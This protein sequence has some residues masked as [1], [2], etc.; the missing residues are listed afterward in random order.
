MSAAT[1]AIETGAPLSGAQSF[2]HGVLAAPRIALFDFY[3]REFR[4]V[5]HRHPVVIVAIDDQSLKRVAQWPWP[6]QVLAQLLKT[7]L[8]ARPAAVGFDIMFSE[9]DRSSPGEWL[10]L[11]GPIPEAVRRQIAVLPSHEQAFADAIA[12]GSVVL[13]IIGLRPQT[14]VA[15]TGPLPPFLMSGDA[16]SQMPFVPQFSDTLRP[17][18]LL[19]AAAAG[20]GVISVDQD[21]D[22]VIR[23][24]PLAASLDGRLAPGLSLEILRLVAGTP[25]IG[26]STSGSAVDHL[27]LGSLQIPTAEDGSVFVHYSLHEEDRFVSA[28]DVLSG[29][30]KPDRFA[31]R[32]VLV[33]ASGGTGLLD[34]RQ[35]P[36]GLMTGTEIQAQLIENILEGAFVTRPRWAESAEL[37]LTLAVGL[38]LIALLPPLRPHNQ[39]LVILACIG[40]LIVLGILAWQQRLFLIDVATPSL[41]EAL[42]FV[43]LTAGNFAEADRQRRRL[44][45]ELEERK[46]A[47]A[48][49]A[50]ELEAGRRIQLG[51]LP[52]VSSISD[53]R[54]DLDARM[55][56][57]KQVG[58][59]LYDFFKLDEDRLFFAIG[60]V[61]GKGVPAAL[62]MALA[63]SQLRSAALGGA[64]SIAEI[65]ERTNRELARNNPEMLFITMF[66]G[67]LDLATGELAFVNAG[68]DTPYRLSAGRNPEA[69]ASEGGPPLCTL[70]DF[71]YRAESALLGTGDILCLLTDGVTEAMTSEGALMGRPRVEAA[72]CGL[73]RD[74][75]ARLVMDRLSDAVH[76]F[77][78]GAEASDDLTLLVIRLLG[79]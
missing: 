49:A 59:D 9:P 8:D 6:R 57:A 11:A 58:G 66:A 1:R 2:V 64:A 42:V 24:L 75:T 50:G 44:K 48:K 71:D 74:A 39:A 73:P 54:V 10:K 34:Y 70:D 69:M 27:S 68:H 29:A 76:V 25:V 7:I 47:E 46:L 35:T 15:D 3:E 21:A 13:P 19:D 26:I 51:M 40:A 28:A 31:Q 53:P 17:L 14:A 72:L 78:A 4:R 36:V 22:G 67:I 41:S 79:G 43:A 38:L 32:V 52:P 33:S 62:F 77:V 56:A 12:S 61:S 63:K 55:I 18:P 45:R 65:M 5:K 30:I 60:D 16:T 37:G 23:R 20:H